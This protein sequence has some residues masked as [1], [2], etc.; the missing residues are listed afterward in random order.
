MPGKL[1]GHVCGALITAHRQSRGVQTEAV[2]EQSVGH[3]L[4]TAVM[5]TDIFVRE[6]TGPKAGCA[7]VDSALPF[8]EERRL[9]GFFLL[10]TAQGRGAYPGLSDPLGLPRNGAG[11]H[12]WQE[13]FCLLVCF[14]FFSLFPPQ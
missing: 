2:E 11:L 3:W 7:T 12:F 14:L 6:R 4:V 9:E 13:G 1:A 8:G 5:A 10:L